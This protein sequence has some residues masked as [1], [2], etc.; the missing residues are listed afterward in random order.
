MEIFFADI[1]TA[2]P[3]ILDVYDRD[4]GLFDMKDDF[5]GRACIF[6]QI[7]FICA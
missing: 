7:L 3:I 4:F 5:L 2:P 1:N 6:V